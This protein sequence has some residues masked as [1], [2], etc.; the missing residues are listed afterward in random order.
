M[1]KG[2][3]GGR[4][5]A[6]KMLKNNASQSAEYLKSLLGELKV[7]SYLGSHPN[8]VGLVGAITKNIKGGEV[9][10]VFE[11]C[12]NGNAH[13]FVRSHRDNFVD[14]FAPRATSNSSRLYRTKR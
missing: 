2:T 8:L 3:Y 7:M 1:V 14:V 11:Y 9:Y 6:I 5:V 10:L 12:A 4:E 13:K